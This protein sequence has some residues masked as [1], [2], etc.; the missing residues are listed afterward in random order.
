MKIS[1]VVRCVYTVL[2]I[3][4]NFFRLVSISKHPGI[5]NPR[6]TTKALVCLPRNT[7]LIGP[8]GP[9]FEFL[10]AVCASTQQL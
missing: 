6:T 1:E 3:S 2:H 5:W 9:G 4:F 10:K 7:R 8:D